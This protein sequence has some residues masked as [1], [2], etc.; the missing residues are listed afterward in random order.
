MSWEPLK[1]ERVCE[2]KY[3][4]MEG[5]RFR[6][7]PAFLRWRHDKT[8]RDCRYGQLEVTPAYELEKVFGA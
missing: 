7:P 6:H 5:D 4:H 8:P 1:I 2:V 3:G